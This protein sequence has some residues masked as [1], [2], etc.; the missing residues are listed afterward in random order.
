MSPEEKK[1]LQ[2]SQDKE[3]ALFIA[4]YNKLRNDLLWGIKP[5]EVPDPIPQELQDIKLVKE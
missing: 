1:K 3:V 4:L 2:M 5:T